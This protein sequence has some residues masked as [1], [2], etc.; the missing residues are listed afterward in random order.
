[1]NSRIP[2]TQVVSRPFSTEVIRICVA[3]RFVLHLH[4]VVLYSL[5]MP[6]LIL[7]HVPPVVI[8]LYYYSGESVSHTFSPGTGRPAKTV[9]CRGGMS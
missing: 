3:V 8:N 9:D 1:M 6:A 2:G 7:N 5:Y 4:L